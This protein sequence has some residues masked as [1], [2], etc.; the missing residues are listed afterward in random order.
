MANKDQKSALNTDFNPQILATVLKRHWY[1][2]VFYI[3][4]FSS[5]AFFYLRYTK[6]TYQ[7]N[8]IIQIIQD[9]QTSRILGTESIG[10]TDNI[11]SKEVELLKSD[12]LFAQAIQSL[13]METS[14]FAEGEVLTKDLYRSAP[15]EILI[16]DIKDSSLISK[17]IDVE[18]TEKNLLLFSIDGLK[19]A[20]G[21]V[22]THIKNDRFDIYVRTLDQKKTIEL[23]NEDDIYFNINDTKSL[24][25]NLKKNLNIEVIDP[26]A[27]TIE[28][29]YKYFNSRLCYDIVNGVINEYLSW[30]RDSKQNTALKTIEFID[31]QLDS[32]SNILR[33]SKDSLNDYQKRV[34][35]LNPETYGEQLSSNIN[36]LTSKILEIDEELYTV[37]II[38]QK[39]NNSPNRLQIYRLIPEMVGKKSFEGTVLAQI[40]DLN[41]LLER[42]DDLLREVTNENIQVVVINE[43]LK[44]RINSIRNSM[45]VVEE[46]LMND[47]KIIQNKINEVESTYFGLPEKKMEYERLKYMEGLNNKYFSLYTEKKIEFELSNAGYSTSNRILTFPYYS[48]TPISPNHKLVYLL[49][50]VIGSIMGLGL[51]ALRYLT[52]NDIISVSD[53]EKLLPESTSILGTVPLHKKKM[54]YSEVVV[55]E[56]SKS[57]IAEAIRSIRSNMS[58]VNKNAQ[59]IAISSSISGEGKTF[60][61]LNLAGMIAANNKKTVLLDLDLRK[62][63]IHH[64]FNAKNN[65]GM[66]NLISGMVS[67]EDVIQHSDIFNLDFITAGPIPPNPSELIES[68]A[69]EDVIASLRE[70]YDIILIDNP[71]VG[72]V[73]DGIKMLSEADIPLY[74]FKAN[75]SKRVFVNRVE[76][77]I[78]VQKIKKL[79][80]IL[81]GIESSRGGYGYGYGY[82]TKYGQGEEG[83]YIDDVIEVPWFKKLIN[84]TFSKW[85]KRK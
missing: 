46:R 54:Q 45:D 37:R 78:K 30:E 67:I 21:K 38:H 17:R 11:L 36:E 80:I 83:Y 52:Y 33:L 81:N 58:F 76:E 14:I 49:Y 9:D 18:S 63:K 74:V 82:G 3:S 26:S 77:L 69:L 42:K 39:I 84:T 65:D 31:T 22:N 61:I 71:P 2:P 56:S 16:Y 20:K 4:L 79:N 55:T 57:R 68:K 53:L 6:P 32:L 41:S 70:R 13:N 40:E 12:V 44:N 85:R 7:S 1:L 35:I 28:I 62:P 34:K 51:I 59:V 75:Y 24:I 66:S 10:K 47:R 60:V 25:K 73:S 43:R 5:L 72:I 50:C 29:S 27:K 8:A 64:G 15:F 48:E 19:I 23:L